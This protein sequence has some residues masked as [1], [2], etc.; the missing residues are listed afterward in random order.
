MRSSPETAVTDRS[1]LQATQP[2]GPDI[3]KLPANRIRR[4]LE[5]FARTGSLR[6]AARSARI[7]VATHYLLLGASDSY[8]QAFTMAQEEFAHTLEAEAFRRALNRSDEILVL[9]VARLATGA[10]RTDH[11]CGARG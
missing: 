8:R 7:S 2:S 11:R 4:F 5:S 1:S 3:P 9:S 6:A 10:I